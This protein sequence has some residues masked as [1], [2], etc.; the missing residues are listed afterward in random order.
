MASTID[1]NALVSM[2]A[3]D[4]ARLYAAAGRATASLPKGQAQRANQEAS[5]PPMPT[6]GIFPFVQAPTPTR[7]L[8]SFAEMSGIVNQMIGG[9]IAP[10]QIPRG[11][12]EAMKQLVQALLAGA[13]T[14]LSPRATGTLPPIGP[15]IEAW[16]G[17]PQVQYPQDVPEQVTQ[18]APLIRQ[19]SLEMGFWDE[20]LERIALAILAA[21]S[22]G[23]PNAVASEGSRGL[24]QIHPVR[25]LSPEQ[26]HDPIISTRN[27]MGPIIIA[28]QAGK[29]LGLTGE[30]LV[31]YV[32]DRAH[33][34]GGGWAWQGDSVVRWWRRIVGGR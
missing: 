5:M 13:I 10:F 11:H 19:I 27:A 22:G 9:P 12:G 25:G 18:W 29:N 34:P 21:E 3:S 17:L 14:A 26:A 2:A 32:Y 20:E 15:G 4:L 7:R 31:R 16:G 1:L 30:E 28:Y 23:N 33:N 24:W 8:G 6:V